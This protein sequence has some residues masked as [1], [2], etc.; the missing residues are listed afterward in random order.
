MMEKSNELNKIIDVTLEKL[1]AMADI[2]TVIGKPVVSTEN[3]TIIPISKVSYAFG[4]GGS[5]FISKNCDNK[6]LFGGGTTAG[7]TMTPMAFLVVNNGSV[8]LL[9]IESFSSALD[10]IVA[11]SPEIFE[12]IKN[13]FK[14][15]NNK[16]AKNEVVE[17]K[18]IVETIQKN[19]KTNID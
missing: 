1:K 5:D 2:D 6:Q 14:K 12:K 11:M 18:K 15:K 3:L 7:I 4:S 10:R 16:N 17:S 9:Q 13:L 19:N 8:Q